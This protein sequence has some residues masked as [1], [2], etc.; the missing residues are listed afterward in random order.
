MINNKGLSRQNTQ[1]MKMCIGLAIV[2][3]FLVHCGETWAYAFFII[4]QQGKVSFYEPSK[5][6]LLAELGLAVVLTLMG[7]S[8]LGVA[9][10]E[11]RRKRGE[12]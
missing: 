5:A 9:I 3:T 12:K 8:F 6:C 4:L 10:W 2:S 1:G 7:L 11:M